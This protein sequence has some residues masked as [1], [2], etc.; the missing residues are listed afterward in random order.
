MAYVT[1][2]TGG[3]GGMGL[4]IAKRLGKETKLLIADFQKHRIDIAKQEL[5]GWDAEFVLMDCKDMDAVKA[6]AAQ[7]QEMGEVK[8]VI[9][10]AGITDVT[11]L[12]RNTAEEIMKN[13]VF[14]V[15]NMMKVFTDIIC[16]GGCIVNI[17][18]MTSYCDLQFKAFADGMEPALNGDYSKLLSFANGSPS[19]AYSASKSY[20]RWLTLRYISKVSQRGARIVSVSPGVVWTPIT[21]ALEDCAPGSI[22]GFAYVTPVGR[23]GYASDVGQTVEFVCHQ[24]FINGC[25]I[26]LDGGYY[27]AGD[28]D[29]ID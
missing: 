18:S 17:A 22:K 9:H 13:N 25:D 14:G 2:I 4:D 28:F 8:Y 7:A 27:N 19:S 11:E 20:M 6:L 24:P 10:A 3:A 5:F 23:N 15:T 29:Q 16:D 1:V 21:Y 12:K 26:L